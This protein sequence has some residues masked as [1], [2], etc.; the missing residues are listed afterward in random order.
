MR[1]L[2]T[3]PEEEAIATARVLSLRGHSAIV[4]PVLEV[5]FLSPD[6]PALRFQGLVVTSANGV[7]GLGRLAGFKAL[8]G[9][10]VFT[11]GE[12]TAGAARTLGFRE[13]RVAA[14]DAKALA[15]LILGEA[16]RGG[17][18][19]LYAAGR[20]RKP[21]LELRLAEADLP[22]LA[23]EVYAMEPVAALS[24]GAAAALEQGAVDAVLH[25]SR[26]SAAAFLAAAAGSGVLALALQAPQLAISRDA[27]EPLAHA[28]ASLIAVCAEPSLEAIIGRLDSGT[29]WREPG[30]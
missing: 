8:R 29:A 13:V 21:V 6:L 9:L 22:L 25:F 12:A 3:R 30:G 26:R 2:V 14:G 19:L 20:D 18:P 28:G 15:N 1:V 16:E 5:R 11:V 7:R 23:L 17:P 24:S 4:S 10:P 27:A